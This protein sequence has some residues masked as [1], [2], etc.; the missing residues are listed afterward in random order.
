[1]RNVAPKPPPGDRVEGGGVARLRVSGSCGPAPPGRHRPALA[2]VGPALGNRMAA[3]PRLRVR[4][5]VISVLLPR[6]GL[7]RPP[8]GDRR[9]RMGRPQSARLSPG[10]C[11][12]LALGHAPRARTHD[13]ARPLTGPP[14]APACRAC[15]QAF[16]LSS[17]LAG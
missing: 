9:E 15:A 4:L 7:V 6:R 10:P 13:D 12:P 5:A 3:A 14:A 17:D 1:M 2:P 8:H 11:R 16:I